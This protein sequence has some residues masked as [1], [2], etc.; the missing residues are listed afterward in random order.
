[1]SSKKH[2]RVHAEVRA[3]L[4]AYCGNTLGQVRR[5]LV[6]VHL[7][8]CGECQAEFSRQRAVTDGLTQLAAPVDGP[9]DGLLEKLL[10]QSGTAHKVAG[11]L[12]GAISGARP[13]Y[14]AALLLAGAVTAAGAGYASWA[15]A[16]H[17]RRRLKR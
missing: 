11:P 1:M 4:P 8:R 9:P 14:S 12:R 5:Q 3:L 16:K 6:A 13:A 17:L 15:S 2:D 7:R 10:E